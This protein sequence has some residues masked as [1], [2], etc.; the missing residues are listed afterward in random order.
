MSLATDTSGTSGPKKPEPDQSDER[1]ESSAVSRKTARTDRGRRGPARIG[2][3][4]RDDQEFLPAALEI[5][6]RPSSPIA[7]SITLFICALATAVLAWS[8]FGRTDVVAV[9]SGK[10]QP[11]G[12]VKTVQTIEG[13]RVQSVFVE[14]GTHVRQGDPLIALDASD[15]ANDVRALSIGVYALR[16]EVF[17]RSLNVRAAEA[18]N[19]AEYGASWPDG[20]PDDIRRRELELHS[21]E[22][23][24]LS[25]QLRTLESRKQ[26]KSAELV[27]LTKT[28]E[29][30]EDLIEVLQERVE[31][32]SALA[33]SQAGTRAGLIDATESL[34]QQMTTLARER[35][36]L[37]EAR[38]ALEGLDFE[39]ERVK[40]GFVAE[41]LTRA[42]AALREIDDMET[43]L[44]KAK[45]RLERLTLRSP[46]DGV[47]HASAVTSIGQVFAVGQEV[48]RIVPQGKTLEIEVYL[49]NKDIGFVKVG[50]KAAIKVEAFP[51]TDYGVLD[52]EVVHIAHDAIPEPDARQF[53]AD[54]TRM[55]PSLQP[56][57]AQRVQSLVF[58]VTLRTEKST[59]D[60]DG[61]A[62]SLMPGMAVTAEIKTSTRRIIEYLL[63]P[64]RKVTGEA[65]RER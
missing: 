40:T 2:R 19:F 6:E 57:G 42:N 31:I 10:I 12:R 65:I 14:N 28:T 49:P 34:K 52:A 3:M 5:L 36:Q 30:L 46:V 18:E 35:G 29:A 56:A 4:R 33:Q 8:W 9:A 37:N 44:V 64:I 48:M 54:P 1:H 32:R 7:K 58:P 43:R 60:I 50:Q 38:L 27:R 55:G 17:R 21:G 61:T 45:E 22:L 53:E 41:N 63:S 26:Q 20:I 25:V 15:A 24:N 39:R 59:I 23:R 11:D 16:A 47:V 62:I 13:G 51:F